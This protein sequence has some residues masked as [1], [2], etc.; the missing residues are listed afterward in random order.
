MKKLWLLFAVMVMCGKVANAQPWNY[1]FG[2]STGSHTSGQSTS[3]LPSTETNGGTSRVRIGTGGGSFNM[4]NQTISFGSGSYLRAVAS[5]NASVNRVS[6]YDYT[7]ASTTF[8]IKFTMRLGDAGGSDT[9]SS[10][11]WYLFIGDGASFSGNT[12]FTGTETFVGI[13]WQFG[14]SGAITTNYRNG[15]AWS[16]TGLSGTPFVQGTDYVV[17]IYGNNSVSS[18]NYTYGTSQSVA[19]NTFDLWINGVL[20]GD[21]LPKA[22]LATEVS[23]DSWSFYGE[24]STNNVANIFLDNF[25]YTNQIASVPLPVELTSF[26]ATA[27][28]QGVELAWKTATEVN[29]YGFEVERKVSSLGSARDDKWAKIG[30]VEGAGNSNA[31]KEY[32]FTDALSA[33]G[34]YLYRLK[35]IDRDGKFEYSHEVEVVISHL[36]QKF[37]LMQNYPNPFNPATTISFTVPSVERATLKVYDLTGREVGTLFN[38]V[39]NP[40]QTYHVVFNGK[41]L[42]SGIY[43]YVL[44]TPTFREVKKMQLIK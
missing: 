21:D 30:F 18:S 15:S 9:A 23:I 26:T 29:N 37:A 39:A 42:A 31:P 3:F 16:S 12:G 20:A 44:Q 4:E 40:G 1:N 38:E 6:V 28:G 22:L 8:T 14:S 32:S 34:K 7:T 41:G 10:G 25:I 24:N 27:K 36:P 13:R 35:Q 19:S 17:E 2:T 33:N 5:T 11:T 43:I